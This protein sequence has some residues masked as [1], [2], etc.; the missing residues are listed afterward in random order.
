MKISAYLVTLNEEKRL[1]KTLEAVSKV[2]DEIIIVDSGSTDATEK[3][4]KKYNAK[5]IYNKWINI[6]NQKNFAQNQC[7][8]KWVLSLDA[9][10]VLSDGLIEEILEIK[11]NG[12]KAEAYKVKIGDMYPGYKRPKRFSKKYNLVRF[13]NR[14]FGNMPDDLTHDRVVLSVGTIPNQ[15][16]GLIHHY[17]YMT[18]KH[19]WIKLND[20]T[21]ELVKTAIV[22][23]KSYGIIRLITEFPRQ[24]LKYYI[25]RRYIFNGLWGFV[26][27]TSLAYVRFL[28]IA[29]YFE[30]KLM[31]QD[32]EKSV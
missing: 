1:P 6:S 8:N 11:E 30:C 28:K 17:S 14:D 25:G 31:K 13:Y 19:F 3:I 27:A 4:A 26:L 7:S 16:K 24:F 20:Y 22:E 5:F 29:K 9:D 32:E 18:L 23:K 2:A 21:D 10:E 15:L 12:P